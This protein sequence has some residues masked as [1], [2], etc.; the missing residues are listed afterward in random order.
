M[1]CEWCKLNIFCENCRVVVRLFLMYLI[2][3]SGDWQIQENRWWEITV[4]SWRRW[5]PA[6][7]KKS[8]RVTVYW[9]PSRR[10]WKLSH[11]TAPWSFP[12]EAPRK[13][14]VAPSPFLLPLSVPGTTSSCQTAVAT[15]SLI[16]AATMFIC[17]CWEEPPLTVPPVLQRSG[18]TLSPT[19]WLPPPTLQ[20]AN[21]SLL[22]A[23]API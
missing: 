21:P 16:W 9:R 17:P 15:L 4:V 23:F 1:Q 18:P 12:Q 6:R 13:I 5:S 3:L 11:L 7:R 8:R 10:Q 2:F 19:S 22:R 20:Q 14:Q